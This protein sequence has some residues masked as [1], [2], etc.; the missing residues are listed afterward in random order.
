MLNMEHLKKKGF[1]MDSKCLLC[2]EAKEDLNHLLIHCTS[3]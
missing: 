2:G 3:V 1:R